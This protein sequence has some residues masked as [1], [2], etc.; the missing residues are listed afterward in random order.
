[1]DIS[2]ERKLDNIRQEKDNHKNETNIFFDLNIQ[3]PIKIYLL[4]NGI[5]SEFIKDNYGKIFYFKN[6]FNKIDRKKI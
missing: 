1:M 5:V 4:N 6:K 2:S 3:N